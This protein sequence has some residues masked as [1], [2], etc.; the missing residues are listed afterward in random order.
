MLACCETP[1]ASELAL[2][3]EETVTN[4]GPVPEPAS[5]LLLGAGLLGVVAIRCRQRV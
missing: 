2:A 5:M 1:I 3:G 4:G